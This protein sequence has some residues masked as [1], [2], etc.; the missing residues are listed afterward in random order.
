[1]AISERQV[2]LF[3]SSLRRKRFVEVRKLLPRTARL[4]GDLLPALFN[5][6]LSTACNERPSDHYSDA[7][8]FVRFL[9]RNRG[10][11]G[12]PLATIEAGRYEA[13]FC[14]LHSQGRA[15]AIKLFRL[16]PQLVEDGGSGGAGMKGRLAIGFW[17]RTGPGSRLIHR[18][19][20]L[21]L[22]ASALHE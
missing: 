5:G 15:F 21:P 13:A 2:A 14:N 18:L 1:M 9:L 7:A 4:T 20:V 3:A 8:G 22:V 19:V 17:L 11:Y 10:K 6:Y 12:L 16:E